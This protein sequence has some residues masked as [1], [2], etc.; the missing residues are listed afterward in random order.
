MNMEIIKKHKWLPIVVLA[1]LA[2]VFFFF[3][4]LYHNDV[5]ELTDFSASYE[6]F[7]KAISDLSMSKTDG[8]ERIAGD[9]FIELNIKA[10]FRLSSLIKNDAKLMDQA[11]EVADLSGRELE[12]LRVYKEAIQRKNVDLD[13][14]V[15]EYV[16]LTGKRKVAYA[17][18]QELA[19]LKTV[20]F[21]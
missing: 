15:K 20:K 11:R 17:C 13:G 4:R 9:A 14:L 8:L 21:E 1:V 12:S 7:D 5:K 2:G 16:D 19:G 18:F 3:Y 10:A 6:K